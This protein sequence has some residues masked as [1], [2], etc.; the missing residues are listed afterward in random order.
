MNR[1]IL[2][3]LLGFLPYCRST[4]D[5]ALNFDR[6]A[7]VLQQQI[8]DTHYNF[9]HDKHP[10]VLETSFTVPHDFRSE[11][12][13]TPQSFVY[14]LRIEESGAFSFQAIK[15][16]PEWLAARLEAALRTLKFKPAWIAQ[17]NFATEVEVHFQV[18]YEAH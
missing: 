9:Y 18:E 14:R 15:P 7:R 12:E 2:L 17:K 3:T 11:R 1:L 10:A 5:S 13:L 4:T 16:A 6:E 8:N